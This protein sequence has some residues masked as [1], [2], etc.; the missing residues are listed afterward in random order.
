[1]QSVRPASCGPDKPGPKAGRAIY[2]PV[3][4]PLGTGP[5][6]GAYPAAAGLGAVSVAAKPPPALAR[7]AIIPYLRNLDCTVMLRTLLVL[8]GALLA[9]AGCSGDDRTTDR[10]LDA[11]DRIVSKVISYV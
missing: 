5:C 8:I 11:A 7:V 6:G 3:L 9:C 4:G 2:S 10:M 1:M